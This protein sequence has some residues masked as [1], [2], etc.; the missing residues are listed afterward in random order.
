[1]HAAK[2][3]SSFASLSLVCLVWFGACVGFLW[4][5]QRFC[6]AA[7][8]LFFYTKGLAMIRLI[9]LLAVACVASIAS[10]SAIAGDCFFGQSSFV[11]SFSSPV[12]IQSAPVFSRSVVIQS[13][14]HHFHRSPVVVQSFSGFGHVHSFGS[15]VVIRNFRSRGGVVVIR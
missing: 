10:P 15:P 5:P 4:G 11:Q 1:M 12:V 13:S 2:T 6:V 7:A 3:S 14:P 8:G 9:A